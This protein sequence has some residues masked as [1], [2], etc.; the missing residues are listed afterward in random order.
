MYGPFT[1]KHKWPRVLY[2]L[3][4]YHIDI[5]VLTYFEIASSL[6][7]GDVHGTYSNF[8]PVVRDNVGY[9]AIPA[10]GCDTP[11]IVG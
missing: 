1:S 10:A 6:Q 4:V 5:D 8:W 11:K 7:A 9:K 3:C 2:R